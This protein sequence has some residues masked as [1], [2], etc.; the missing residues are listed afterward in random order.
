MKKE[1]KTLTGSEW[2]VMSALW[3][4]E[5][6]MLS[7]VI[8]ALRGSVKWGYST[9]ATHLNRLCE[10]GFAGYRQRGRNRFYYPKVKMED[11]IRAES[12]SLRER[13][14]NEGRKQLLLCMIEDIDLD[15]KDRKE[16]DALVERLSKK[17]GTQNDEPT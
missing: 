2:T 16:L 5:P 4:H 10:K 12:K 7:E 15:E 11:C 13:L 8:E 17:R 14:G 6:Q 9:Y 3:G 1:N